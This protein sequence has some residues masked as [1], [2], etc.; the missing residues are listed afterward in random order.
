MIFRRV[1]LRAA[2]PYSGPLGRIDS[3]ERTDNVYETPFFLARALET[4]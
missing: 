1:D 3:E 4:L 2:L